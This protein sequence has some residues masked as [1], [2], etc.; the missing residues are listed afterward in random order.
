MR[1]TWQVREVGARFSVFLAASL[2]EGPQIVTKRGV[3][4]AVLVSD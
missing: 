1:R 3:E 4:A 2:T